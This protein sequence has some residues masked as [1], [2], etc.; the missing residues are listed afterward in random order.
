ML[1]IN[2]NVNEESGEI[3]T[4]EEYVTVMSNDDIVMDSTS[5]DILMNELE[6][7][8]EDVE[9]LGKICHKSY[10]ILKRL[11]KTPKWL[12]KLIKHFSK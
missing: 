5:Y 6:M 10:D 9:T 3:T 7:L 11:D 12:W 2:V 1:R 4:T 8:R